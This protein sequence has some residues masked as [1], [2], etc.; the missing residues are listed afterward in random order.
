MA[1]RAALLTNLRLIT[2]QS[3]QFPWARGNAQRLRF[4]IS[5]LLHR[6]HGRACMD[7]RFSVAPWAA[8]RRAKNHESGG[9]QAE[10]PI[11]RGLHLTSSC[12]W[13]CRDKSRRDF[14]IL[15]V[16]FNRLYGHSLRFFDL[17]LGQ[18]S[19]LSRLSW[20]GW[21]VVGMVPFFMISLMFHGRAMKELAKGDELLNKA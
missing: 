1:N 13:L 17:I 7:G 15:V 2:A 5:A 8:T 10:L 4:L 21:G 9:Q 16:S 18:A 14:L 6:W 11:A 3:G 20:I 19:G 12:L